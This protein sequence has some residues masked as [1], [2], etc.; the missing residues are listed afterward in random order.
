MIEYTNSLV[1]G[2][3]RFFVGASNK[4]DKNYN[5]NENLKLQKA[6]KSGYRGAFWDILQRL[7]S[8]SI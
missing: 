5:Y 7:N 1:S 2:D 3:G 4:S 8:N 6:I